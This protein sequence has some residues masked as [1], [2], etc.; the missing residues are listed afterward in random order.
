[1][2]SGEEEAGGNKRW[3]QGASLH[4]GWVALLEDSGTGHR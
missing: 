1:M 4:P 3:E 2:G